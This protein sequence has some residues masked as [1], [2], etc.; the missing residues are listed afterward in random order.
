MIKKKSKA[1]FFILKIFDIIDRVINV[2]QFA[3]FNKSFGRLM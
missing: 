1:V 3:G 2:K